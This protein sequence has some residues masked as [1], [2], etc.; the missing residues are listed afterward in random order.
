[1]SVGGL[2]LSQQVVHINGAT[3]RAKIPKNCLPASSIS[4]ALHF[5]LSAQSTAK[6]TRSSASKVDIACPTLSEADELG[7]NDL[8]QKY[9]SRSC[10]Q[11]SGEWFSE[12]HIPWSKCKY[13]RV[14]QLFRLRAGNVVLDWGAGC[15]ALINYVSEKYNVTTIAV[16]ITKSAV[17]YGRSLPGIHKFC[18]VGLTP[19]LSFLPEKHVDAIFSNAALYHLPL[20]SQ[21]QIMK[22]FIRVLSPGGCIWDGWS[23]GD[24]HDEHGTLSEAQLKEIFPNGSLVHSF[25]EAILF[26]GTEYG[27]NRSLSK[28]ICLP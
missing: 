12:D 15:G 1:M 19:M 6:T 21:K 4:N 26:G 8:A 9:N 14:A 28:I 3:V 7:A 13:D 18:R 11:D 24:A 5:S 22:E 27:R 20:A 16:D 17:E 2:K 23:Y 10:L 25:K